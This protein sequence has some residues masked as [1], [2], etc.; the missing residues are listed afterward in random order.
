MRKALSVGATLSGVWAVVILVTG[1]ID[2]STA[3]FCFTSRDPFRPAVVAVVLLVLYWRLTP[4]AMRQASRRLDAAVS[5]APLVAAGVSVVVAMLAFG[6]GTAN[7]GGADPYGYLSE[8]DLWRSGHLTIDQHAFDPWPFDD[9]TLTPLGYRPGLTPRT[10]VPIYSPGLPLLV[11]SADLLGGPYGRRTVLPLLAALAVWL[12]FRLGARLVDTATGLWACVLLAASPAFLYHAMFPMSD[13]PAAAAWTLALVLALGG[14][15]LS[16]G[17]A[18]SAAVLVRPNL[19]FL[20]VPVALLLPNASGVRPSRRDAWPSLARFGLAVLPGIVAVA[21][22]NARLYGLPWLSGYGPT[23]NLYHWRN[24]WPNAVSYTRWLLQTQSVFVLLAVPALLVRRVTP[25]GTL[26]ERGRVR[27]GLGI[28]VASLAGSYLLYEHF[29]NWTYL[30]FLL[31]AYPVVLVGA[32]AVARWTAARAAPSAGPAALG[33]AMVTVLAWQLGTTQTRDAMAVATDEDRYAAVASDVSTL[34]PS[35]SVILAMQHSGTLRVLRQS[36]DRP[37]PTSCRRSRRRWTRSKRGGPTRTCCSTGGNSSGSG[38]GSPPAHRPGSI[39]RRSGRGHSRE[40]PG[41]SCTT[42]DDGES[43]EAERP[44]RGLPVCLR[45]P[46]LYSWRMPRTIPVIL[47]VLLSAGLTGGAADA[48]NGRAGHFAPHEVATGLRGGYQV[49]IADLNRDGRPDLL[50]VASQLPDLLWFENPMWTRH[51]IAGSF[52]QMI[53]AAPYDIDGDGIPEI[54]LAHGFSMNPATSAGVITLL[55]HLGDPANPWIAK[56]IDRLPTTH[57]IRWADIDGSGR[58]V[59]V[60]QPL[61]GPGATAPDYH[62]QTPLVIYRPGGWK[63]E[64]IA[65]TEGLVHGIL[66]EDFTHRGRDSILTAGFGGAT[67]DEYNAGSWMRT[68]LTAGDPEPW[69][70]SGVSDIAVVHLGSQRLLATIEPWHGNEVAV[71]RMEHGAWTRHV[72]DRE[73]T[74]G[75]TLVTGDLDGSGRDAIV[76][77]ERQGKRSVYIYSARDE[78]GADWTKDVLDDGGMAAA[79]CATGDLNG[80]KRLDIACIGT[81]TANLKWYENVAASR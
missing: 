33:L 47:A 37:V 21:A 45:T 5:R 68:V 29:D 19:V 49:V 38:D 44:P 62:G 75:H 31:P 61:L 24:V 48:P 34:T 64:Q 80:D 14:R 54:A 1:G 74:D 26:W 2:W 40:E 36:H 3:T 70:K 30:R 57:R 71:Y 66:I 13:V 39:G 56:E 22:I 78:N 79:G 15:P 43:V 7:A 63:R 42:C 73:I 41:Y 52:T 35:G 28:F 6:W 55:T 51:V 12:A 65:Q 81:A 46:P 18:S 50:A 20:V 9:W 10:I 72:I 32:V 16:A 11:A 59:L 8:A 60:D 58:K 77:G 25:A 23:A 69:P 17:L 27:L 53:N 76:V 4:G 67:I